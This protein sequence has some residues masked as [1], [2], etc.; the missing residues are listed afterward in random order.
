MAERSEAQKRENVASTL[1][2][3]E[4]LR[5]AVEKLRASRPAPELKRP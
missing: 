5:R 1:R 2:S 3:V 4:E